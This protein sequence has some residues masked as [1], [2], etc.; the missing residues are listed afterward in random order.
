MGITTIATAAAEEFENPSHTVALNY[1]GGI[2]AYQGNGGGVE[3]VPGIFNDSREPYDGVVE[4]YGE[5]PTP[6]EPDSQMLSKIGSLGKGLYFFE[7]FDDNAVDYSFSNAPIAIDL[8]APGAADPVG[9][10]GFAEGDVLIDIFEVIGSAFNDIIRG[11]NVTDFPLDSRV[12]VV[13][14]SNNV[15]PAFFT[16]NNPG[17]NVLVGGGGSDVLEGRG[18]ADILI[19]GSFTADFAFDYASYETSPAAVTVRLAGVGSD[20]QTAIATGGDAQGDLLVGIEGLIGSLFA[21]HLTGNS[22]NNILIGGLGNDTLDG[23]GGTDTVDYSIDHISPFSSAGVPDKVVVHLG[24]NGASGSGV[25]FKPSHFVLVPVSTDTLTSIE[26][27]IGT[28][29][30]DTLIGNE[31]TNSLD[32]RD[33]SDLVDGGT[34]SDTLNGGGGGFDVVTYASHDSLST[35]LGEVDTISLG[36]NGAAGSYTRAGLIGF[37]GGRPQFQTVETDVLRNFGGVTGS[38]KAET[39]NGNEQ[40]NLLEGR[41]GN[42]HINGGAGGDVYVFT[43]TAAVGNDVLFDESGTDSVL[44]NQFSDIKSAVQDGNDLVV[45][46][47]TGTFRVV[48]HFAGHAIENVTDSSNNT[49]VLSTSSVGGSLPGIIGGTDGNDTLGGRGGDDILFGNKGKDTLLGGE[50]NDHL[51][52]GK[53][54]DR[55]E[56]GPGDDNLTGGWGHD[57]FVF[58]PAPGNDVV[59]D[60]SNVD[61]I[62]FD[63]L[64]HNF[65]EVQGAS[66]QVGDDTVIVIDAHNSVTLQDTDLSSLHASDFVFVPEPAHSAHDGHVLMV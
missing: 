25:E 63:G 20:T 45:T 44:V 8:F 48:D 56:G 51:D 1:H 11:S 24:L 33:G 29:G 5:G 50:G 10:G 66:H 31:Q 3:I 13:G 16:I 41:G 53:D 19:G 26:N 36:L 9:H 62:E 46:L 65:H 39:I 60:F 7:V 35:L 6:F 14:G 27:V 49:M 55:L 32:G 38:N 47:G 22:L 15:S 58:G 43:G 18:G 34:G 12:N 21:D 54:N 30:D 40:S 23:R 61:A 52:G 57:T 64:F 42:D 2:V 17:D 28:D 59:T 37:L 4:G